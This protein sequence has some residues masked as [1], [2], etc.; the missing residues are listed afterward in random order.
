[1]AIFQKGN[2]WFVDYY[3]GKGKDRKR[4]RE[5][6]G[7]KKTDAIARLGKIQAAKRENRL[8]DVKKEYTYTF[9]ELLE[10]Y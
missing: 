9:D 7:H 5:S 1:M 10:R 4:I 8:F 6:A 3:T 2:T